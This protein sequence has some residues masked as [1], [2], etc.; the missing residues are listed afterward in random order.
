LAPAGCGEDAGHPADGTS[1]PG[2]SAADIVSGSIT[3]LDAQLRGLADAR[4]RL[5]TKASVAAGGDDRLVVAPDG[6]LP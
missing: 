5:S 6:P 1:A 3:S 2:G 4:A